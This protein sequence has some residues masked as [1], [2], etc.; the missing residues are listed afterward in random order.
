MYYAD[1]CCYWYRTIPDNFSCN[2]QGKPTTLI[3]HCGI[4]IT[5]DTIGVRL[6]YYRSEFEGFHGNLFHVTG[7]FDI[8][9]WPDTVG[10]FQGLIQFSTTTYIN[11][12]TSSDSGY[13]WC[14]IEVNNTCLLPSP[15]ALITLNS[16][17]SQNCNGTERVEMNLVQQAQ[18]QAGLAICAA[19]SSSLCAASD[20][21]PS[22]SQQDDQQIS[23]LSRNS[24]VI[25]PVSETSVP[26]CFFLHHLAYR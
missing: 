7:D 21:T 3:F 6:K 14:Q 4:Y 26:M 19:D 25:L 20:A 16:S 1:N 23:T 12:F 15:P 17:L 2:P 24:E 22:S 8:F 11:N 9:R 13:Y 5:N 18:T 10:Y